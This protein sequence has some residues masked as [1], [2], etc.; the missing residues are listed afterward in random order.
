MENFAHPAR[1][2]RGGAIGNRPPAG[3][4]PGGRRIG[5]VIFRQSADIPSGQNKDAS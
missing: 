5:R 3:D 1:I 2:Y 4:F